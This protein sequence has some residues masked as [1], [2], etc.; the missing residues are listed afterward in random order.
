L[1]ADST[2]KKNDVEGSLEYVA[3]SK[4]GNDKGHGK[5][6]HNEPVLPKAAKSLRGEINL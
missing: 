3:T 2:G 1:S 4:S 5:Q 6:D